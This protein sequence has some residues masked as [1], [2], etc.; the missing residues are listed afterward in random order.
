MIKNNKE[1]K[2]LSNF[3]GQDCKVGDA[4]K[5]HTRLPVFPQTLMAYKPETLRSYPE[6]NFTT[7]MTECSMRVLHPGFDLA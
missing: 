5:F 1:T 7:E 4:M 3:H 2:G 6:L